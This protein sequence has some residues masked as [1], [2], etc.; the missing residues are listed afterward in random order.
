MCT[1]PILAGLLSFN[2][3][4]HHP[5]YEIFLQREKDDHRQQHGKE[6]RRGQQVPTG[7]QRGDHIAD[8]IRHHG[9]TASQKDQ[10]DQQI[11]PDP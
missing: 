1:Y 7:T 3:P 6:R 4:S 5:A 11:V 9:L 8:L 2:S 10:R